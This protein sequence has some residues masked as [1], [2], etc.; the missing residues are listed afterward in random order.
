MPSL[1][2]HTYTYTYTYSSDRA[3]VPFFHPSPSLLVFGGAQVAEEVRAHLMARHAI[4]LT[5]LPGSL[6]AA[7]LQRAFSPDGSGMLELYWL[8]AMEAR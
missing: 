1:P 7:K 6:T 2:L 4:D 3:L 8:P 5:D